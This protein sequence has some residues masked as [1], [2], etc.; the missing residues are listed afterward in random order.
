M[1]RSVIFLLLLLGSA[2]TACEGQPATTTRARAAAPRPATPANRPAARPTGGYEVHGITDPGINNLVAFAIKVP[3]GWKMQQS[4]TR[5]W[6]GAVPVNQIYLHLLAPGGSQE[7]EFFPERHYY[8]SDGPTA[9]S[10]RQSS[11]AMGFATPTAPNEIAPMPPLQYIKQVLLPQMAQAGAHFQATGEHASPQLPGQQGQT[12]ATAYVD[13]HLPNGRQVRVEC[14][15][16]YLNSN[17]N[18]DIFYQWI[19]YPSVTQATTD[20]AGAYANMQLARKSVVVNPAWQQQNQQLVSNGVQS[21]QAETQKRIAINQDLQQYRNKTYQ[22]A[23]DERRASEDRRSEAFSD[24][25]RG[26]AKYED[27][28]GDRVKVE[29]Q[30]S[31][32]YKND[33]GEYL[34]SNT[35]INPGLV[36][37]QE[38]QRVE[39]KNY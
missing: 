16:Q 5:Q 11:A 4:F 6:S 36:N 3:R 8:F 9:R 30:Y 21:N 18:G 13:G 14:T 33:Q 10:L 39:T 28:N 24:G 15:T 1:N 26:Q 37:W 12:S 23:A 22:A 34:G 19:A 35:P 32:V 29:D 31:H 38:L 27:A 2:A 25:I 20:L 17:M 7:I